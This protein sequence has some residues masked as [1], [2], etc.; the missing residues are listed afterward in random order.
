MNLKNIHPEFMNN[1]GDSITANHKDNLPV[2][3]L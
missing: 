3:S 1:L 2:C